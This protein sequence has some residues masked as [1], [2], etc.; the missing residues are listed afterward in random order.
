MKIAQLLQYLNF[1]IITAKSNY[2]FLKNDL[3]QDL[4]FFKSSEDN[5]GIIDLSSLVSYTNVETVLQL[6]GHNAFID[7]EVKEHIA[8]LEINKLFTDLKVAQGDDVLA[9]Y[10]KI[11]AVSEDFRNDY[12]FKSS[13][14]KIHPNCIILN[15]N[16][17]DDKTSKNVV[18]FNNNHY[19]YLTDISTNSYK[20]T[21]ST[22]PPEENLF[23]TSNPFLFSYNVD[24]ELPVI[25]LNPNIDFF[26]ISRMVKENFNKEL[27]D[28]KLTIGVLTNIKDYYFA[29][30]FLVEYINLFQ[31][32]YYSFLVENNTCVFSYHVNLS[33]IALHEKTMLQFSKFS[34]SLNLDLKNKFNVELKDDNK[35]LSK[36]LKSEKTSVKQIVFPFKIEYCSL[37]ISHLITLFELSNITFSTEIDINSTADADNQYNMF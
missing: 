18:F 9:Q 26:T 30:N 25:L 3:K 15:G 1:D 17:K 31:H 20:Y 24:N 12:V 33:D 32:Y 7:E 4:I 10:L 6:L 19:F 23:L 16:G 11:E 34:S 35:F 28:I 2:L 14:S 36:S 8:S 27:S 21:F 37:F 29:I 22:L 13:F 5:Y